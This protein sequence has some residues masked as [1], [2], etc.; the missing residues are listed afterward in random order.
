MRFERPIGVKI[1]DMC[2]YID[3]N[4]YTV[5]LDEKTKNLIFLY[6]YHIIY[7][8]SMRHNYFYYEPDCDEFSFYLAEKCYWR[9]VNPKQFEE[10]DNSLPKINSILNYIKSIIRGRILTWQQQDK[11]SE[12]LED[13]HDDEGQTYGNFIDT[14]QYVNQLR[15]EIDS[16]I[17]IHN[18]VFLEIEDLPKLASKVAS[19]TQF[20][21]DKQMVHRLNMSLILSFLNELKGNKKIICWNLDKGMED[22]IKILLNRLKKMFVEKINYLMSSNQTDEA[23]LMAMLRV[24][25]KGKG[26][27]NYEN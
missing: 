21:N 23:E 11:F 27:N 22:F 7:S 20:K 5:E 6:L 13:Y 15:D 16:T 2:K 14:C 1:V 17:D 18:E 10:G 9:L 19:L 4:I 26:D 25:V 12:L 3:D 8:I 24:Q